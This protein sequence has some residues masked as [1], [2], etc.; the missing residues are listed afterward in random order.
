MTSQ[1]SGDFA[2][3]PLFE[4]EYGAT[5]T[6]TGN[7]IV[8]RKTALRS[9]GAAAIVSLIPASFDL[10]A[11]NQMFRPAQL[12]R[13]RTAPP[14][15][16]EMRTGRFADINAL[17]ATMLESKMSDADKDALVADLTWALPQLTGNT[18]TAFASA[19]TQTSEPNSAVS[20]LNTGSITVVRLKG[21]SA[22]TGFWG[23]SRWRF[24]SDGT[25]SGGLITLDEDFELS[26]NPKRRALRAHELGHALGMGHVTGRVS[27][28]NSNIS[29]FEP[30]EFD[31]QAARLAF[32]RPPGNR[33]P[34]TDPTGY[35]TNAGRRAASTRDDGVGPIK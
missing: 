32:Q 21:L 5:Y 19:T 34:D 16:I 31:K 24:L 4:T 33:A 8:E 10:R 9:A 20:I 14:L 18:F 30:N 3:N 27:I 17:D 11:F 13:W 12:Q 2:L 23:Y 6:F 26:Q 35:S 28:M 25:I 15:R 22:G 7:A 29:I 1:T